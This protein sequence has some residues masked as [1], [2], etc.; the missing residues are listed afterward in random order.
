MNC[1]GITKKNIFLNPRIPCFHEHGRDMW[2]AHY[3]RSKEQ[4]VVLQE[5][6]VVWPF[7]NPNCIL[8]HP[9]GQMVTAKSLF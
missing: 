8:D 7:S 2:Q 9:D 6:I 1:K 5:L 3:M 4:L